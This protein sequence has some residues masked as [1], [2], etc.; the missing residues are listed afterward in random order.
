M[1]KVGRR[2]GGEEFSHFLF[3]NKISVFCGSSKLS[4]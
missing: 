3:A 1:F 2:G 4:H